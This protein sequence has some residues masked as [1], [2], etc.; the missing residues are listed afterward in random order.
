MKYAPGYDLRLPF[1][2]SG[3][4]R[5]NLNLHSKEKPHG[6]PFEVVGTGSPSSWRN[7]VDE[8]A[9]YF[10][11]EMKC[12]SL[13][14]NPY[15]RDPLF[16][17]DRMLVFTDTYPE[18][19]QPTKEPPSGYTNRQFFT[20]VIAMR[21]RKERWNSRPNWTLDWVWFHPFARR[22]GHLARAWPFL[23]QMY[24]DFK[25][26]KPVSIAMQ[27]FLNKIG[28][29]RSPEPS[30]TLRPPALS[31]AITPP[32]AAPPANGVHCIV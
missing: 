24:P 3:Q 22:R 23:L 5:P 13:G 11:H 25:I 32:T 4:K 7:A 26:S 20:G 30:S 14:Y 18:V 21:A 27:A 12:E 10:K 29:N 2:N 9:L 15:E 28:Y 31:S 16:M 17:D 8:M 6:A 1:V 19:N